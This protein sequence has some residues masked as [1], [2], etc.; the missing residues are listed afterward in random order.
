MSVDLRKGTWPDAQ[1]FSF[2]CMSTDTLNL[3]WT[4]VD[5][6]LGPETVK[7]FNYV[8]RPQMSK[9]VPVRHSDIE[10]ILTS[11]RSTKVV[12]A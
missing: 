2:S 6:Q 9:K 8:A 1:V 4:S 5:A 11:I 7:Y 10:P 3:F 12:L